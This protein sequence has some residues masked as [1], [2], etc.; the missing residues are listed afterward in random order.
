MFQLVYEYPNKTKVITSELD[1]EANMFKYETCA[2]YPN[3]S[4]SI[5]A[6]FNDQTEAECY[7]Q[8]IVEF[9]TSLKE[10]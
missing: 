6:S 7:H 3:G 8:S 2:F 4:S 1:P 10:F 5:L 9:L